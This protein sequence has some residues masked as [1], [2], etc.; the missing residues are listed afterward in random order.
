M[1]RPTSLRSL[2]GAPSSGWRTSSFPWSPLPECSPPE[3]LAGT[4]QADGLAGAGLARQAGELV[5]DEPLL[6][7]LA[8]VGPPERTQ[9]L[10]TLP[11]GRLARHLLGVVLGLVVEGGDRC[12]L[13]RANGG[14]R[15]GGSR[16]RGAA[17]RDGWG[18]EGRAHHDRGG[19]HACR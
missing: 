13:Q 4:H 6:R 11:G 12:G 17:L 8:V 5:A 15:R 10:L 19:H 2:T 7:V 3:A 16:R 18:G 14:G 1:R 9:G